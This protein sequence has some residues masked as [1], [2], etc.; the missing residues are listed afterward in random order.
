MTS[1]VSYEAARKPYCPGA[2]GAPGIPGAPGTLGAPGAPGIPGTLGAPGA[3]PGAPDGAGSSAP[4]CGQTVSAKPQS[5][6]QWGHFRSMLAAD[7]LKHMRSRLLSY[8][9]NA[10]CRPVVIEGIR[11]NPIFGIRHK[12]SYVFV[13]V[14]TSAISPVYSILCS[15]KEY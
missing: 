11:Q 13:C 4:H 5:A 2:L 15:G 1:I 7:G 8:I 9:G 6:L 12:R 3:A 14:S 10:R